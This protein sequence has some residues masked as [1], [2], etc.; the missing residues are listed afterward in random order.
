V[1]DDRPETLNEEIPL[2]LR[3][4]R[5]PFATPKRTRSSQTF[6]AAGLIASVALVM[7]AARRRGRYVTP[8]AASL[9]MGGLAALA[10]ALVSK[11]RH[12]VRDAV[13]DERIRQTFPASDPPPAL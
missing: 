11:R 6:K 8:A 4:H 10:T 7:A 5:A 2:N 9:V 1:N 13:I 3:V 12:H